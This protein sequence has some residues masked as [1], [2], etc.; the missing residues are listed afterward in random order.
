MT[1]ESSLN[2]VCVTTN[3]PN[4]KS[5]RN[6]KSI[7]YMLTTQQRAEL[8][9]QLSCVLCVQRNTYKTMLLLFAPL[10]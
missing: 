9:I 1:T 2:N 5:N 4:T 3:R 7:T 10:P 6:P 8:S